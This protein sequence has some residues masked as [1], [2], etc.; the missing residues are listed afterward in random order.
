MRV[1]E[2]MDRL[3]DLPPNATIGIEC[4]KECVRIADVDWGVS[5]TTDVSIF[6]DDYLEIVDI[7]Y[8]YDESD[9]WKRKYNKLYDAISMALCD[10]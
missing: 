4:K 3:K 1:S 2:L 10:S 6:I 7:D 8:Q 5:K 9:Y